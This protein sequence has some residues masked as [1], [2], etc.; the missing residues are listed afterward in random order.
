VVSEVRIAPGRLADLL[1][2]DA[3]RRGVS[4]ELSTSTP[5]AITQVWAKE[6][7]DLGYDGISYQA[8]FSSEPARSVAVFGRAGRPR[9][10]TPVVSTR[11][12]ADVLRAA[13][14][15]VQA[16]PSVRDLGPLLD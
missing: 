8:R 5:Y 7:A 15:S 16:A 9:S 13:G 12:L 14:Y 1:H 3:A 10:V 2:P 6:F 4:R 11:P